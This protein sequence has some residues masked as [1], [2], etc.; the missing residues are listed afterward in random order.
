MPKQK[1]NSSEDNNQNLIDDQKKYGNKQIENIEEHAQNDMENI[2]E[3]T[4]VENI[5]INRKGSD[6]HQK[7][8]IILAETKCEVMA[9]IT[10]KNNCHEKKQKE[11]KSIK[12][13]GWVLIGNDCTLMEKL[14]ETNILCQIQNIQCLLDLTMD[15]IRKLEHIQLAIRPSAQMWVKKI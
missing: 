5:I 11:E 3:K 9:N 4:I 1:S 10:L 13:E 14:K 12:K 2:E 7:I 6:Q 8:E 15:I